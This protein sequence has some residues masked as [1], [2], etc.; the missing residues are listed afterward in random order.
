MNAG[1]NIVA[2]HHQKWKNV[3]VVM[4][5][6]SNLRLNKNGLEEIHA[7]EIICCFVVNVDLIID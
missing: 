4:S 5:Q 1:A 6:Y 7:I 2:S 3:T